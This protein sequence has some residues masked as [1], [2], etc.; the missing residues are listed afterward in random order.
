MAP[1]RKTLYV[2]AMDLPDGPD[3]LRTDGKDTLEARV[4]DL[5]RGP[6]AASDTEAGSKRS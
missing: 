2:H 4:L 1:D 3:V 6:T 5:L